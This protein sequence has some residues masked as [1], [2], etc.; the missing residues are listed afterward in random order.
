MSH[1]IPWC[2][3]EFRRVQVSGPLYNRVAPQARRRWIGIPVRLSLG[4]RKQ[5][6]KPDEMTGDIPP[7][8]FFH[9]SLDDE[10][11]MVFLA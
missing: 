11:E 5:G 10:P 3:S 9:E 6:L 2:R 7:F 8:H 4:A 1:R